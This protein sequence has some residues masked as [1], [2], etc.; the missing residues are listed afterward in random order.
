MTYFQNIHSLAEL[1]KQ[2]RVLALTKSP[3]RQFGRN[4]DVAR[5]MNSPGSSIPKARH[6]R[7][8]DKH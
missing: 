5:R 1:K 7:P 8:Y 2:Y 6:T 3:I 4:S